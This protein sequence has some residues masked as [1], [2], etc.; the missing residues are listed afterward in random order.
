MGSTIRYNDLVIQHEFD[1][2][3]ACGLYSKVI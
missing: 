2:E 3:Y 1:N